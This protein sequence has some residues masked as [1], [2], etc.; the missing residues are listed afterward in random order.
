MSL[1][2]NNTIYTFKKKI[3]FNRTVSILDGIFKNHKILPK[4][5]DC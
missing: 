5:Q 4:I 2:E 3:F 1:I